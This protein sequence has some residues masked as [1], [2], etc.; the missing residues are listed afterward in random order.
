MKIRNGFVSNSSSSSFIIKDIKNQEKV[1]EI[2]NSCQE[3]IADYYEI[4]GVLITSYIPDCLE[5]YGQIS[6]LS[7][8]SSDGQLGGEPYPGFDDEE[9]DYI[10]VEGDRGCKSIYLPKDLATLDK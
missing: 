7:D 9:F 3:E 6:R 2:I 5:L 8:D 4:N 1:K 10:V